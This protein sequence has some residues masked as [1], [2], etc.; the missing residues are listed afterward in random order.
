[1]VEGADYGIEKLVSYLGKISP[2]VRDLYFGTPEDTFQSINHGDC[3]NNNM[4][5]KKDLATGKVNDHIF[6]DLQVWICVLV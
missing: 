4:L 5:F 2:M 3:W 1:V 6:V